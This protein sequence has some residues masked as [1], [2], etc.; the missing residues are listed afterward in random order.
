MVMKEFEWIGYNME[1]KEVCGGT[2]WALDK[3]DARKEIEKELELNNDDYT[4]CG[5]FRYEILD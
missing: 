4:E 3:S 5:F 1:D 2:V